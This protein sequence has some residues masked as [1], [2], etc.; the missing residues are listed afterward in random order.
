LLERYIFNM[1]VYNS[2][3]YL[4]H[5][6]H[7]FGAMIHDITASRELAW[8][9]FLRDLRARYR[10]SLLGYF[11]V[12]FPPLALTIS[13]LMMQKSNLLNV[14]DLPYPYAVY[15]L[16][17]MLFWQTLSDAIYSPVKNLNQP[18]SMLAKLSFP[19]ESLIISGMLEVAFTFSVRL[20]ILLVL[21]LF[22]EIGGS[23]ELASLLARCALVLVAF[24]G[25]LLSGTMIGLLLTPFSILF[26]DFTQ[27]LPMFISFLLICTPVAYSVKASDTYLGM[28]NYYNPFT[29][30]INFGREAL[31]GGNV[32]WQPFF[33]VSMVSFLLLLMGWI[34]F[35][36]S[37]P[38][39]I[40][41]I[42][43]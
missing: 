29:Y 1:K 14:G 32:P 41:R 33:L 36:I 21:S 15:A 30:L 5:P 28:I 4:Y 35:R 12:I 2:D 3:P 10:Q 26:H 24:F 23:V 9:L 16:V 25:I 34:V 39:L 6:R 11:W 27:G 13:F 7:F 17:G 38:H 40:A 18:K 31:L 8:R 37:L 43:S 20:L 22:F 19:R 42:G